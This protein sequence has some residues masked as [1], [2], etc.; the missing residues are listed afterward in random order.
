[1]Y[2]VIVVE[3]GGVFARIKILVSIRIRLLLWN[4]ISKLHFICRRRPPNFVSI[5]KLLQKLL[6]PRMGRADRQTEFYLLVLSSQDLFRTFFTSNYNTFSFYILR[7]WWESKKNA[8][9]MY[10]TFI[11]LSHLSGRK[12]NQ[13]YIFHITC[14]FVEL[15]QIASAWKVKSVNT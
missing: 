14:T 6:C 15:Q 11:L 1:M 8:N 2:K 7:T 12:Q 4:S 9:S 5:R 3:W 10:I 13:F